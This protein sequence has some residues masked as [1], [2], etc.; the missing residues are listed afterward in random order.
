MNNDKSRRVAI[1][2][3]VPVTLT[4][5]TAMV[6]GEV[7]VIAVQNVLAPKASEVMEALDTDQQFDELDSLYEAADPEG[8]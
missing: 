8:N 2:V 3:R 7:V 1:T 6:D 5:D 4:V